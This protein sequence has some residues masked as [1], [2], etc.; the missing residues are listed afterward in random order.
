MILKHSIKNY[1]N[2]P[3]LMEGYVYQITLY[4]YYQIT[5]LSIVIGIS[6]AP[7]I[8]WGSNVR[9]TSLIRFV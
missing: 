5:L 7:N 4:M 2:I 8:L 6:Q 1:S 9:I 3:A